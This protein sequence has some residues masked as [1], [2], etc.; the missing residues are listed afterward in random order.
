MISKI[1]HVSDIHIRLSKRHEEYE[2]VFQRLYDFI[3][4]NKDKDSVI[5]LGGDIV[6][7][8]IELSPEM[9]LL[10]A[11]FLKSCADI[12][13]TILIQG[14]HD[15]MLNNPNRLDSLTPIV[16][17]LNHPQLH[18]WKDSGVYELGG[19]KFSVFGCAD[20][21]S[22]WVPASKIKGKYKIA[23]HH[24]S[25]QGS[26][27]DAEH[28]IE[29][30]ITL[31]HFDGFDLGMLGDIHKAQFLNEDGTVGYS[32]SLLQ[33]NYGETLEGHGL[34]VWDLKTRKGQFTEIPND[35][36]YITFTL[37][38]TFCPIPDNLPP[39]LRVRIK[40]DNSSK[41][42]VEDFVKRLS[43]KYKIT[44]LTKQKTLTQ[45]NTQQAQ[46]ILGNSRD[47]DYQNQNISDLLKTLDYP[48]TDE[49]IQMVCEL[50]AQ[51]NKS[52]PIN[53]AQRHITWKPINLEWENMFSYGEGNIIDFTHLSGIFGLFDTNIAGKSSIFDILC[54]VLYDKTTRATK[55]SHILNNSK[56][57]FWC[58][59]QFA[60]NGKDYFIERIGTKKKDGAVKVDVNFWTYSDEID[61][62][63]V[64]LNGEDRDKTNFQ[65]R[66]YVGTYDDFVMTALSTQYDNQNFI[67][68]T[69]KDRKELLYKFL[70]ITV[71]DELLKIAKEQGKEVSILLREYEREELHSKSSLIYAQIGAQQTILSSKDKTLQEKKEWLKTQMTALLELNKGLQQV[72]GDVSLESIQQ[73]IAKVQSEMEQ[74]QKE[75]TKNSKDQ[76]DESHLLD[77]IQKEID[78]FGNIAGTYKDLTLQHNEFSKKVTFLKYEWE[79]LQKQLNQAKS[80]QVKLSKHEYDPNCQYCC[81][82][83]FVKEASKLIEQIP[84]LELEVKNKEIEFIELNKEL[85]FSQIEVKKAESY[86]NLLKSRENSKTKF[87]RFSDLA[88]TLQYKHN[89]LQSKLTQNLG[90]L[91]NYKK[92]EETIEKNNQIH[93][94]IKK[95]QQEIGVAEKAISKLET[96]QKT[97]FSKLENLKAQYE[98]INLKLDKYLDYVKKHRVYELYQTAVSRDGVPYR[99]LETVLPVIEN[100]VN[101][102][103]NAMVNFTVKLESTEDKYII[104]NIVYNDNK[105]WPVE[106]SS[107]MERFVL[108]LAF[109]TSLTEITSL[110]KANFLTIDE[111]FGV[112]D[113]ENLMSIG[114]LFNF[115]KKQYDFLICVSHIEAM[116]DLVDSHIKIDKANG[117]SRIKL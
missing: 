94:E 67:E 54:F 77:K 36:G 97:E 104:A 37:D 21:P 105:F 8:K 52:L 10:T 25:V 70:D 26:F 43:K 68:K 23:L 57:S 65:I 1:F 69:Q 11:K 24:G 106:L 56:D 29:T 42:Q 18:Y 76:F 101:S 61:S 92:N 117:Y 38:G 72:Y 14:N 66:N 3:E 73:D 87:Q 102:I 103:L 100:E 45:Q 19:V 51:I 28:E 88:G 107:G 113:N 2:L 62:K 15:A 12:L 112:L 30:G 96:E 5:F 91:E 35:Y 114:N 80:H 34:I 85:E 58:K 110:P 53:S 86:E 44:E 84:I 108:S 4:K 7:N 17:A 81:N 83:E 40:H 75:I 22:K 95:L 90:R 6:H 109:R 16:T 33:Q 82:N 71:Y 115:L 32:S 89:S 74:C 9:V 41:E 20:N 111:G 13:P 99:I 48:V 49:E 31:E 116:R 39:N 64:M 50:N 60:V 93:A 98:A 27:T 46:R 47:V 55:A 78:E 63:K 59:I 79:Q